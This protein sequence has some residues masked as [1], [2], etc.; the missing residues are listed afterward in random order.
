MLDI[1]VCARLGATYAESTL[2]YLS[3]AAR[4]SKMYFAFGWALLS[5]ALGN[6]VSSVSLPALLLVSPP[7]HTLLQVIWKVLSIVFH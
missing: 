2:D 1:V 6:D 3:Y 7:A 5:Y 4:Q